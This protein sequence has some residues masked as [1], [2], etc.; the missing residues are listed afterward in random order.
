[1]ALFESFVVT[2]AVPPRGRIYLYGNYA[3]SDCLGNTGTSLP[4]TAPTR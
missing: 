2:K 3:V 1:M 4:R